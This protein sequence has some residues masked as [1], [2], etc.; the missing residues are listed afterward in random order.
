MYR[1][2]VFLPPHGHHVCVCLFDIHQDYAKT[3]QPISV[4]FCGEVGYD[5]RK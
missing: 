3:T 4:E 1:F 5:P 2:V